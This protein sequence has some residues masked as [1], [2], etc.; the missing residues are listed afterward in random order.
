MIKLHLKHIYGLTA[1]KIVG[2]SR[3]SN[4]PN[5][6]FGDPLGMAV[7]N[8]TRWPVKVAAP[9]TIFANLYMETGIFYPD[10]RQHW[11]GGCYFFTVNLLKR[12]QTLL[13]DQYVHVNP[14]NM[15]MSTRIHG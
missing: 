14:L 2:W 15:S 6:S 7:C 5:R 13:T 11:A 1:D 12:Q 4:P 3:V 10:S 9:S 8:A